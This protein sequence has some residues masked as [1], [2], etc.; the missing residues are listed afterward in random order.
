M[1]SVV[2]KLIDD[3][4]GEELDRNE[5]R[6]GLRTLTVDISPVPDERD[7]HIGPQIAG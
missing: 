3:E 7:P 2:F 6:I 5:K 1:Y 4:S